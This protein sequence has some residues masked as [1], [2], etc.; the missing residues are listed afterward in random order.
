M[1]IYVVQPGDTI[2]S[3][4]AQFGVSAEELIQDNE[5]ASPLELVVGQTIV[6]AYPKQI[7]TVQEGDTLISIAATYEI[8]VQQLL[9]N[10]PFLSGN[11]SVS[12]GES[13]VISYNTTRALIT[14]G[15]VYPYVEEESLRKTLPNLTYMT[16]YNYRIIA[17]GEIISYYD[18]ESIIR[19]AREYGT[20][21]LMMATTVSLQ[22]EPNIDLVYSLLT[23]EEYQDNVING[24][25]EIM[26]SKGYQGVNFLY[27]FMTETNQSLYYYFTAKAASRI[28]AE[29]FLFF[30]T[31][32][33]NVTFTN[34][35]AVNN[36]D[37]APISQVADGI[38][39]M[40]IIWGTNY[41]PPSPVSN[42]SNLISFIENTVTT[43]PPEKLILGS[44]VISYDWKL[45]FIPGST[46]ANALS[47]NSALG[48]AYDTGSMI[49]F[50]DLS[51]T[52]YF[53]YSR[54]S[55]NKVEQHIVWSLD[56]RSIDS[57]GQI[58]N[59]Y[60]LT[61]IGVWNVMIYYGQ[62]W[63][64]LRAQFDITKLLPESFME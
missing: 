23:I 1:E 31:F 49:Q 38:I 60:S 39:F 9:R 21:T 16:V 8:T 56:A 29:G 58:V 57:I 42:T 18:D 30:V 22:G 35:L 10:N 4:A 17:P 33:L 64:V 41:G 51:M 52:P 62:L 2:Y 45:P 12:P 7:Y 44:S 28:R 53:Y 14:N 3:I 47:I 63:L 5:L 32:N 11:A 13:L 43:L 6:I 48:L 34:A 59:N 61:G 50:D 25:L 27:N 37:Y 46:T 20:I 54:I 19:L 40:Q 15:L 36:V 55:V 24:V 26:K